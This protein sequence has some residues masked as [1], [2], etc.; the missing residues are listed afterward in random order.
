MVTFPLVG[1]WIA[2]F[3]HLT[4]KIVFL[5]AELTNATLFTM[6]GLFVFNVVIVNMAYLTEILPEKD[7]ALVA[8]L[9][10]WLNMGTF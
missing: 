7:A 8:T 4:V 2:A 10:C 9:S 3:A 1:E 6:V 5:S